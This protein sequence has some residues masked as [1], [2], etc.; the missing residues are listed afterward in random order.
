MPPL[1]AAARRPSSSSVT[2]SRADPE[3]EPHFAHRMS[4][5][6][7][8]LRAGDV[9][10]VS[11]KIILGMFLSGVLVRV[12]PSGHLH[13]GIPR[14]NQGFHAASRLHQALLR[15]SPTELGSN[16]T[17][18]L[19]RLIGFG[20]SREPALSLHL[21]LPPDRLLAA[22]TSTQLQLELHWRPR[23]GQRRSTHACAQNSC[24]LGEGR[25]C[26]LHSLRAP[27]D[28]LGWS[29]WVMAPR[30][31]DVRMCTGECSSQFRLA[32]R[33][34]H[35]LTHLHRLKREGAPVPCCV[36]ASSE[37]V[38]L[39]HRD[40]EGCMSLTPFDDLVANDCH[41]L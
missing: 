33:H 38:V 10:L 18:P 13:L 20:V 16:M 34:A 35:L 30:E 41:C 29:Y 14:A 26:R 4:P 31:R 19:Q 1:L 25:C 36:P 39:F 12:G 2:W 5:A 6:G 23:G 7:K 9:V 15:L 32:N 11:F 3:P 40:S 28:D 22:S 24:R 8:E 37:P 27:L 17:G 21:Q